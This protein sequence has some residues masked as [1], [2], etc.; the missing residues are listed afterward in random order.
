MKY[1]HDLYNDKFYNEIVFNKKNGFFVEIGALDGVCYSQS[2]FFEK[3]LNWNGIVVEP[4]PIWY[5]KI[6][7][8]RKCK[9]ATTPVSDISQVETFVCR[10][11]PAFSSLKKDTLYFQN[12]P[13]LSEYDLESLTLTDL[14]KK[15]NAPKIIDFISV[16]VEGS[17]LIILNKFLEENEYF[18]NLISFEYWNYSLSKKMMQDTDYIELK[19]PFTDFMKLSKGGVVKLNPNNGLFYHDNGKICDEPYCEL[20]DIE[21]EHYYVHVDYLKSNRNLKKYIKK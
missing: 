3:Y 8:N 19:N 12:S 5:D 14:L 13:I 10:E 18:V 20:I 1:Y 7:E 6:I 4:N 11:E 2:Y 16:D 17:E 21:F 15:H 9:I